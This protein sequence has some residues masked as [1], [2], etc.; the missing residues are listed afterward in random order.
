MKPRSSCTSSRP[1]RPFLAGSGGLSSNVATASPGAGNS[2]R[3]P[4]TSPWKHRTNP[5]PRMWRPM[6]LRGT[7]CCMRRWSNFQTTSGA[8][9]RPSISKAV[10]RKKLSPRSGLPLTTVKKRLHSARRRLRH[11]L[12]AWQVPLEPLAMEETPGFTPHEQLFMATWNGFAGK[13]AALLRNHPELV[14]AVNDDGMGILLFA[15][16]A[17]HH[18]GRG[19]VVEVLL[20]HGARP[21]P[22]VPLPSGAARGSAGPR[23][24]A[25]NIR[26]GG[27]RRCTGRRVAGTPPWPST[28]SPRA[29]MPTRATTGGAPPCTSPRISVMR[30]WYRP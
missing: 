6:R 2:P 26:H 12:D 29:P 13:C 30:C 4:L 9:C 16:H 24:T 25:R 14:E 21:M 23:S 11:V 3:P 8:W 20:Q 10:R 5:R 1:P 17:Q 28:C 18:T 7:P 15:A 27:A 22:A 19:T